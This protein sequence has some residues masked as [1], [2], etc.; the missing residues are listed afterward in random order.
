MTAIAGWIGA[1]T[2]SPEGSCKAL[3]DGQRAYQHCPPQCQSV[4]D[5]TF[6]TSVFPTL[7]EDR[8]D[9]GPIIAAGRFLAAADIRIDNRPELANRLGLDPSDAKSMSDSDL[10]AAAWAKWEERCLPLII[11]DFA[12]AIWDVRDRKLTLARDPTGQRPLF[13]VATSRALAFSSTPAGLLN[14]P[15]LHLRFSYPRLAAMMVGAT[16]FSPEG[17]FEGVCR[18]LPGHLAVWRGS[19]VA[20]HSFW[21]PPKDEL[22]Q[23]DDDYVEAYREALDQ[24]VAA[25]LRRGAGSVG[26]HLSAGY[27]SSAVAATAARLSPDDEP[28][29]AFTCAPR[30]GFDGPVPPGRLADESAIA[31]MAARHNGMKHVVVRPAQGA[32]ANLR[33]HARIYQDPGINLVNMEWWTEIIRQA[34]ERGISTMLVG[35]MGNLGINASGLTILPQWIRQR[36]FG[37]W[38]AEARAAAA[39]S[40]VRWR[41]ILFNSFGEWLP[42]GLVDRLQ[43]SFRGIPPAREQCFF[44]EEWWSAIPENSPQPPQSGGRYPDR[45]AAIRAMDVGLLRKGALGDCGIDER[46]AMADLRLIDFSFRLPPEQLLHQGRYH[47]LSR[48]ALADR[49]P[50]ELLDSTLRGLQ[51]ADWHERLNKAQA[52]D[53]VEEL[54]SCHAAAK[55]LDIPRMRTAIENWPDSATADP[56]TTVIY[57]MRL[58]MA[59]ATGAFIQEFAADVS[60]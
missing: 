34:K 21:S 45:L 42:S 8:F 28:V 59:L 31:A 52:R 58:P 4:G 15:A 23:S 29:T 1:T 35:V 47:P 36:S 33:R 60:G 39:R 2:S 10:F 24:A 32:L 9:R 13:F 41:G 6:G 44:R 11:G 49:L 55:L 38:F 7:P 50:S 22:R 19:T 37:A 3:L 51:G 5:A 30:A 48:R 17:H 43:S 25:R 46:D 57:R 16:Q 12:F 14:C 20:Q 54:A 40:D 18:V 56:R 26:T 53:I 27:D